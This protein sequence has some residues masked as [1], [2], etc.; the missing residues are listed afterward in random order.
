MYSKILRIILYYNN[1]EYNNTII[2]NFNNLTHIKFKFTKNQIIIE[3]YVLIIKILDISYNIKIKNKD[4]VLNQR[5]MDI[6]KI[7]IYSIITNQKTIFIDVTFKIIPSQF[8]SYKLFVLSGIHINNNK[9]KIII[10]ILTKYLNHISYA[11]IFN[12]LYL[13]E[14]YGF[15]HKILHSDFEQ[16]IKA[17][18]TENTN[19]KENIIHSRCFIHYFKLLP[20]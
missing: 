4:T 15:K 5:I 14:N 2:K 9:P 1:I 8:K 12:Y 16:G 13:Y 11:P 17:T 6:K 19:I 10:F 3:I 7:L 18:I 20:I